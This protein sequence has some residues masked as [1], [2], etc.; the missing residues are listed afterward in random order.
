[1]GARACSRRSAAGS[2]RRR[3]ST[4]PRA[5]SRC[6]RSPTSRA[7]CSGWS[8]TRWPASRPGSA[9]CSAP[10]TSASCWT[11]RTAS[12][13]CRR[14]PS[15]EASVSHPRVAGRRRRTAVP[16]TPAI[17]SRSWKQPSQHQTR[18]MDDDVV[19]DLGWGHLVFGQTFRDLRGI[20]DALRAEESGR[21]DI[22]IYPRDP[23]VLVG[24]AP[25]ELFIDPSYTYRLDLHRYRP[26]SELI[27]D[28]FVR[29]VT[30]EDE[31]AVINEIYARN[32]MV[33]G[34]AATMWA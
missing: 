10:S 27:R 7:R 29:T 2:C 3:S 31:M 9:G 1:M 12:S 5:T 24:L 8:A 34:D 11:T 30:A 25:D 22:C 20:V 18:G 15:E 16:S 28:V 26:R 21:R 14:M 13:R 19:L 6:P 17:T 23:H 33:V 32:G 4:A